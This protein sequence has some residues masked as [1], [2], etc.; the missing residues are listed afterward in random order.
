MQIS[1]TQWSTRAGMTWDLHQKCRTQAR[2]ELVP[3]PLKKI[4]KKPLP[5][6]V[7]RREIPRLDEDDAR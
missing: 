2:P 3:L 1:R 6:H 4:K 5:A 7:N